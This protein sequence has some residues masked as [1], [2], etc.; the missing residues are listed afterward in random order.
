MMC[1]SRVSQTAWLQKL[2]DCLPLFG[3][4]NWIVIADAAYPQQ[5]SLGIETVVAD[6][7]QIEAVS[8]VLDAVAASGHVRANV[9][10]DLELNFVSE[11]DAPC[12]SEYRRQLAGLVENAHA[13]QIPHEE[14]IARLEERARAFRV[15]ILKTRM[16]IPY[17]SVFCELECG[18]WSAEAEERLRQA[19]RSATGSVN[20]SS[21]TDEIQPEQGDR[22]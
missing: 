8:A 10:T 3:H 9:S 12:V 13:R 19:M 16:A 1:E 6:V 17:T 2:K 15:L 14:I 11:A 20:A 7:D 4:R 21:A 18:Y 22:Q 5:T